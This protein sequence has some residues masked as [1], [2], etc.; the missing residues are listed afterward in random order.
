MLVVSSCVVELVVGSGVV[1]LVV[2]SGVVE[3]VVG[4]I[5]VHCPPADPL[6]P[7]LQVHALCDVLPMGECE[8]GGQST[9]AA[10]PAALLY[11][12]AL[13]SVHVPSPVT[14]L[15]FPAAHGSHAVP[16]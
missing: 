9:Q 3:L 16:V 12:P 11:L 6:Y 4:S 8:F 14:D 1:E 2:G 15:Y 13:Q 7:V 10:E 5:I